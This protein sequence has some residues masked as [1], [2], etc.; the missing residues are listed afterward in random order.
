MKKRRSVRF[1]YVSKVFHGV[2][3]RCAADFQG[4]FEQ[5]LLTG[6][7]QELKNADYTVLMGTTINSVMKQEQLIE[8]C[9][10]V[11]GIEELE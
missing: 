2:T 6:V 9:H 1:W 7:H 11:S 3:Q 10:L 4:L 8:W 5:P